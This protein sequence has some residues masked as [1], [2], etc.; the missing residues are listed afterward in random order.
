MKLITVRIVET[1]KN[2]QSRS[3]KTCIFSNAPHSLSFSNDYD[4][5]EK[6]ETTTVIDSL[7]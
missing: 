3:S 2:F 4:F 5:V 7:F 6:H 1:K